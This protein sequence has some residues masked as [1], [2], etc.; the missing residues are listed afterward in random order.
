[1][2]VSFAASLGY[3]P[4][5]P[6]AGG[7]CKKNRLPQPADLP[8]NYAVLISARNEEDVIGGLIESIKA[9]DYTAG[10]VDVYVI[11]DNCTDETAKVA[12]KAGAIVCK[13][14][15]DRQIG[16][17]YA[18]RYLYRALEKTGRAER[19][20]G[21]FIFDADNR[22]EPDYITQMNRVFGE[23]YPVVTSYRNS[24]NIADSHIA[25]NSGLW[26]LHDAQFLNK[27]RM[28][29]GSSCMVNGT[30]Y[31]IGKSVLDEAG[32]WNFCLMTEDVEF[33]AWCIT[34]KIQIGY[35]EKACFYDTQPQTFKE[36]WN[37]RVRWT[38]GFFD[39]YKK[40]GRDL[41]RGLKDGDLGLSAFDML[42][43][44]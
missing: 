23:E 41:R 17:G 34:H 13:R 30:G 2:V 22:L 10:K 18:L 21:F 35:C 16:K 44:P 9:Q 36:S 15:N 25:Y 24:R 7:L 4:I 38:R 11:A 29:L 26:F 31:L 1:M 14:K 27:S 37:Q 28:E 8:R 33:N 43:M 6:V 42:M 40:Y 3:Q 32:G 20:D 5:Y 12:K 19:Y 39:V